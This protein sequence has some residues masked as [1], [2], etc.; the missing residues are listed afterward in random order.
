MLSMKELADINMKQI[1]VVTTMITNN[2]PNQDSV[3]LDEYG[4]LPKDESLTKY[5]T[6]A[7]RTGRGSYTCKDSCRHI[8][9]RDSRKVSYAQTKDLFCA[10]CEI[11]MKCMRCRCCGRLGRR[12]PRSRNRVTRAKLNGS[13]YIE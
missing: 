4:F 2:A 8:P 1:Y 13:K 11:A 10:T 6:K 5:K 7:H 9:K 3:Q 12:E